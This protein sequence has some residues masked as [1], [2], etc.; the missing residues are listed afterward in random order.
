VL[1]LLRQISLRQLTASWGRTALV[2]GGV[3][4]GVS[5]IV[6][7]DVVKTSVVENFRRTVAQMAGPAALEVALGVGEVGFD[8]AAV[9]LVRSDAEV[10]AAVPLVRGTIA[11]ADDPA[12]TLQLFGADFATEDDLRRYPITATTDRR[13]LLLAVGEPDAVLVT[14]TF[15]REH[16]LAVGEQLRVSS[17][18]GIR[19]LTVRGL[20]ATEGLAAAFAGRLATM[21]LPAAQL[22]LDK[23]GRVDQIDVVVRDGADVDALRRR[24]ENNLPAALSVAPPAQRAVQYETMLTSFRALLTGLSSLCLVAGVFIVYNATSTGAAHRAWTLAALR[25]IGADGTTVL[26]LLMLEAFLLGA[27]GAVFGIVSGLLLAWLLIPLVTDSM[28]INFQLRFY[29]P[30]LAIDPRRLLVAA[31]LG[32]AAAMGASYFAA[33]RASRAAP[34]D[35][36]RSDLGMMD[37][38]APPRGLV[39]WWLALVTLSGVAL[40]MQVQRKSAA[41]GNLGSSLFNAAV[42]IVA[43]PIAQWA[44]RLVSRV[45]PALSPATGRITANSLFRSPVR[46]G[47]TAAA[48]ALSLSV[49]INLASVPYSFKAS[50]NSYVGKFLSADLIVSAVATEGGWLES[51]VPE[52]LATGIR[53]LPGVAQVEVGRVLTGQPF[54]GARIGVFGITDRAFDPARQPPG[55]YRQGD[56]EKAAPALRAGT[57]VNVSTTLADRYDLHVGDEISLETP[58]GALKLPIVG[59]VPDFVSDHGSV[60][61]SHRLIVERWRE[62]NLSRINVLTDGT[63]SLDELRRAIMERFGHEHR[64]KVLS[65]GEVLAYHDRMI[66][67]AFA[68]TDAIQLLIAIVTLCCI[69]DQ[70]VSTTIERRRELALWR[71]VGAD[72]RAV[73]TS[74]ML[75]AA[76]VGMLGATLGLGIGLP[77]AWLWI[78]VNL[79]YLLGYDL[80]Y[81]FGALPTAISVTIV[82]VM[83]LAAGSAAARMATRQSVL[84][85]IRSN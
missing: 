38:T 65:V 32:I 56:P 2:V 18:T 47:V 44:G 15:A 69:F 22:L 46:T 72:D 67:R 16:R 53:M 60:I 81:H 71:V 11:L 3:A 80:E 24:L 61:L 13:E 6:A 55:W 79:R 78:K 19:A 30:E 66:S 27:V 33:R 39:W 52:S 1:R 14:E 29:V 84:D 43:I 17:P 68:F 82:V 58:T 70:L 74:V 21:D 37:A 10:V 40:V 20:L 5:L 76:T 57:G 75:E 31:I 64:L 42:V 26:R 63:H 9:E 51:P 25:I 48:I 8:E 50:M 77:T 4:T 34:I 7:I 12:E 36:L 73:R 35:V 62:R 54:R 45:L 23:V 41:W 59:V 83:T 28:G 49:S 85:G